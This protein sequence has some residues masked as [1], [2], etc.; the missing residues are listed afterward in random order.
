M[1][2]KYEVKCRMPA[3]LK[4][5]DADSA[6]PFHSLNYGKPFQMSVPF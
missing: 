5:V 2:G 4:E 3:T 6:M 1:K